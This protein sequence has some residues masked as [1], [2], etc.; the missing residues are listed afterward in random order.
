[1]PDTKIK[2]NKWD[3]FVV[4]L[5]ILAAF[6]AVLAFV[7]TTSVNISKRK[8]IT[9]VPYLMVFAL[10]FPSV[11]L[12]VK[13]YLHLYKNERTLF[14]TINVLI[15]LLNIFAI[16]TFLVDST[17]DVWLEKTNFT[18]IQYEIK[19]SMRKHF[20]DTCV[21]NSIFIM[22]IF[23]L[24]LVQTHLNI[25]KSKQSIIKSSLVLNWIILVFSIFCMILNIM[26]KNIGQNQIQY[27]L[28]LIYVPVYTVL[29]FIYGLTIVFGK[30]K[31]RTQVDSV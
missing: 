1:M 21:F 19:Y 31:H 25:D 26:F 13:S 8:Y 9:Q 30:I 4:F 15:V 7:I 29:I 28:T 22:C 23:G 16:I 10:A 17:T 20:E 6:L 24:N 18:L 27:Y 3:T 5:C 14:Y 12:A 2:K 11:V